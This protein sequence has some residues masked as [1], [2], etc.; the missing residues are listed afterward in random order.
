MYWHILAFIISLTIA[1]RCNSDYAEGSN[2]QSKAREEGNLSF[3]TATSGSIQVWRL[4]SILPVLAGLSQIHYLLIFI[5]SGQWKM[6]CMG[7]IFLATVLSQQLWNSGSPLLVQ[8]VHCWQK[9][10]TND[11]DYVEK[12]N[13]VSEQ[14][15]YQLVLLCSLYQL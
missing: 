8:I 6:N 5:C 14:L 3:I 1:L 7:S 4:W 2:F 9:C 11:G 10:K 15:H 12:Q 13:F